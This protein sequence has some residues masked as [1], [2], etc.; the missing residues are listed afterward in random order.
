MLDGPGQDD[1]IYGE[2]LQEAIELVG[3]VWQNVIIEPHGAGFFGQ[4]PN[5]VGQFQSAFECLQVGLGFGF[6][7]DN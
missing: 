1:L 4:P 5:Y 2:A 3:I 7:A 6:S